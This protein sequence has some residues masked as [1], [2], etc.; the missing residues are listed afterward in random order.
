MLVNEIDI[1][2]QLEYDAWKKT[3]HEIQDSELQTHLGHCDYVSKYALYC[4][5]LI[6]AC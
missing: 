6:L 4:A 1:K 5:E 3:H 2:R